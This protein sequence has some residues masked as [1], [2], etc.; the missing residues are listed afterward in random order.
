MT[1]NLHWPPEFL[2]AQLNDVKCLAGPNLNV[3]QMPRRLIDS[4][5]QLVRLVVLGIGGGWGGVLVGDGESPDDIG[6]PRQ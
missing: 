3:C 2:P 4:P 6:V 5:D 1:V